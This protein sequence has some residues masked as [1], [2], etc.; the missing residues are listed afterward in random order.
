MLTR[1]CANCHE[2]KSIRG[3]WYLAPASPVAEVARFY[4][5]PCFLAGLPPPEPL[6]SARVLFRPPQAVAPPKI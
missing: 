1:E 2:Q 3:V 6:A 5:E 4:C